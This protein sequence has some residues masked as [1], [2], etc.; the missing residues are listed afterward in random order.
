MESFFRFWGLQFKVMKDIL[1]P[2][3]L[4]K[5]HCHSWI[6]HCRQHLWVGVDTTAGSSLYLNI[7]ACLAQIFSTTSH[8]IFR[9]WGWETL[10]R[11]LRVGVPSAGVAFPS[12]SLMEASPS[13][14]PW[15]L[16]YITHLGWVSDGGGFP[17]GYR[18]C[19]LNC[20]LPGSFYS[21]PRSPTDANRFY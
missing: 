18:C 6:R 12:A 17:Q 7:F 1:A 14:I 19:G 15:V 2:L 16:V 9:C 21:A 4:T 13:A 10:G 8:F 3:D 20:P 5:T 11:I